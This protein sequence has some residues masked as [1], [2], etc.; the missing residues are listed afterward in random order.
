MGRRRVSEPGATRGVYF[1]LFDAPAFTRFRQQLL[2]RLGAARGNASLFDPAA[3]SP[4]LIVAALDGDFG[5][6]MPLRADPDVDCLA[7]VEVQ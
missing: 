1:L 3:L 2:E 5:R 6:W 7:P 4:V